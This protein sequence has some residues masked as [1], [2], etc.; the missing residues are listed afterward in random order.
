M[1]AYISVK[2]DLD[3]MFDS[4]N[5]N[6]QQAFLLDHLDTL[7]MNDIVDALS[8]E[9]ILNYIGEDIIIKWLANRDYRIINDNEY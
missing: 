6:E 1:E 9:E 7:S 4:L 2:I 8:Y 3:E 5:S